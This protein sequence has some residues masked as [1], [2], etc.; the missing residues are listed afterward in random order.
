M[1][2]KQINLL[3]GLL[4]LLFYDLSIMF[5]Y[6]TI[7][8]TKN[9]SEEVS[10]DIINSYNVK[11]NSDSLRALSL[12]I[13]PDFNPSVKSPSQTE[14]ATIAVAETLNDSLEDNWHNTQI[15]ILNGN[16]IEGEAYSLV[17]RLSDK[18][19]QNVSLGGNADRLDYR[20]TTIRCPVQYEAAARQLQSE[21][22]TLYNEIDLKTDGISQ[23]I[24]ITVGQPKES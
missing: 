11:L 20:V 17:K 6:R 5:L 18:G 22:E 19:Y 10:Q 8:S 4:L 12:K 23:Q 1:N 2:L 3:I 24:E 14:P 9:L 7:R 15:I 13:K 21:L 16:G